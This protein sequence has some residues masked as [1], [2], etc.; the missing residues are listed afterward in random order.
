MAADNA[1]VFFVSEST[2][3]TAQTMGSSILSQFPDCHYQRRFRPFI[4]TLDKARELIEEIDRIFH[5]TNTK[6]LVFA[7]MPDSSIDQALKQAPCHYYELFSCQV[8]QVAADTGQTPVHR[9]GLKHGLIDQRGYDDRMAIVN[10]ALGHDDAIDLNN[11]AAADVILVGV[12]RSGKTP[13][14][15]YLALYFGIR[16]ANYP[17]TEDDFERNELP[18]VLLDQR[19]KLLALTIQPKRL[20]AIRQQRTPGSRYAT[21]ANC[22]SEVRQALRL[23]HRHH[24][25]L[26]DTTTSSIEELAARIIQLCDLEPRHQID[27]G[28]ES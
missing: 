23:Y 20:Q 3:I 4:N 1:I 15:L 8:R 19:Q 25:K 5:N 27:P 18:Q 2:G 7:T 26:L 10:Y 24:L 13:T 11:L 14:S 6:P 9:S 28:V 16:A 12:S 21:L 17:L 22:R